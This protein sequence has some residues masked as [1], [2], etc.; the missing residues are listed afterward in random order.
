MSRCNEIPVGSPSA[1]GLGVII[2]LY[3]KVIGFGVD[4]RSMIMEVLND[5]LQG[6]GRLIDL[7]H[8]QYTGSVEAGRPVPKGSEGVYFWRF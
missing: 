6:K 3:T 2:V 4:S 7:M 5:D 1:P 8:R